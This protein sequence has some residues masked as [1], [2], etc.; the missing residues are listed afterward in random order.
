MRFV[1]RTLV[2]CVLLVVVASHAA[3]AQPVGLGIGMAMPQLQDEQPLYFYGS[4]D[5]ATHPSMLTPMDSLTFRTGAHHFELGYGP[6]WLDI[7]VMKLDYDFLYLR[8]VTVWQHWVEVIV[9]AS[10]PLPRA[11]PR[12]MWVS[13]EAVQF[14]LWPEFFLDV[15]S[16][17]PIDATV[18]PLRSGP[19]E[20]TAN[21][22]SREGQDYHVLAV[23]DSWMLVESTDSRES[24]M[25][26]GWIRWSDGERLLV[27]FNLLS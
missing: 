17:E 15:Y 7:E 16:V 20:E 12:T 2:P 24:G 25:P 4:P 23:Q 22:G 10:E 13:R 5:P 11:Y 6:P 9:N 21:M 27:R 19:G 18:N 3:F 1:F 26:R 14:K 8:A